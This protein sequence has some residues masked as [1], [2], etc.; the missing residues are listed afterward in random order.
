MIEIRLFSQRSR[1]DSGQ[2]AHRESAG[3]QGPPDSSSSAQRDVRGA[4]RVGGG[5]VDRR[6]LVH[7]RGTGP[8]VRGSPR[9]RGERR[10]QGVSAH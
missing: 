9:C 2:H 6:Q 10:G 1:V 3:Y 8:A 4:A 5:C 7:A